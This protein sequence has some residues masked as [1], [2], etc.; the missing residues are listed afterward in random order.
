MV[1]R[2]SVVVIGVCAVLSCGMAHAGAA[3]PPP[4]RVSVDRGGRDANAVSSAPAVSR[5]GHYI[6]FVSLASD[7]VKGDHNGAA[8]VFVRDLLG[9]TTTLVS[10]SRFGGSGDSA[11]NEPS[12]SADGRYVAFR[13]AA[14]DLVRHDTNRVEDVFVRDLVAGRTTRVS[15]ATDGTQADFESEDPFISGDGHIVSFTSDA[16]NLVGATSNG[17]AFT[18]DLRTGA[19]VAVAGESS[20][21]ESTIFRGV[22][23]FSADASHVAILED[24][25]GTE[26]LYD[27]VIATGAKQLV[28]SVDTGAGEGG[29]LTSAR[30]SARGSKLA[31]L[32]LTRSTSEIRML[33]LVT[34]VA[35]RIVPRITGVYPGG[36]GLS[37]DGHRVLY[38]GGNGRD[39]LGFTQGQAKVHSYDLRTHFLHYVSL[40]LGGPTKEANAP[41]GEPAL[42]ADGRVAAFVCDASDIVRG[43]RN[44]VADVFARS[45][46]SAPPPNL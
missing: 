7:L 17:N 29:M 25:S 44:G 21:P 9:G 30:Y 24:C 38:V 35:H 5:D 43:D 3:V 26:Y 18:H 27:R 39:D 45:V 46:E 37:S 36:L 8:D 12:I 42:G 16:T 34:D 22:A 33:D 4:V 10:E 6:A 20:C 19:T 32:F 11:S 13:S 40:P 28:D 2:R 31:W 41:C 14:H 15:V 23:A 1:G